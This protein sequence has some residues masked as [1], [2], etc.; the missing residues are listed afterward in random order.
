VSVTHPAGFTAA[1]VAA[2]LKSTGAKDVAVLVNTGPRDVVAAVWTSNRCKANP[3]LWSEQ[4]AKTGG[5]RVVVANSGGANCYTGPAGFQNTHATAELAAELLDVAAIEVVVCSTGLIGLLNDRATLLAGVRAAVMQLSTDGDADAADAILTTDTHAK[6]AVVQGEGWSIGGMAKGAGML[7]P[8]LATMLVFLTTDADVE[9]GFAHMALRAASRVTFDRLDSDGCMST[10][11]SVVL[12]ASG[13]SG[14]APSYDEFAAAL[15]T[16]CHDLAQQL[17]RD[18]EG[19]DHDIAI[20]AVGAAT[21]E[22]AVEV[23]R[24]VARSNLFKCAIYGKDPNWGRILAAVGT[25]EA[26]FDPADLDVAL[27]GVW[28]CRGSTP[29]ED[30]SLVDLDGRDVTVTIDLKTGGS[31]ATVWTN[32]LTHAYVHENSAY[33]S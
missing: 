9:A 13:A 21:E 33:A 25:T 2:G 19:A 24:S 20:T 5:A 12:M 17:L 26:A 8:G 29:A 11:D 16:L 4:V 23:A 3:V 14:A 18:A 1:G 7:A 27:N 32:D 28:L 31:E 15:T 22:D 30:R 10:N 6:N